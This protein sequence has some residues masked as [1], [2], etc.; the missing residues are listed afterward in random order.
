MRILGAVLSVSLLSGVALAQ[1]RP[2]FSG[3]R[4]G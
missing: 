1:E 2:D 4:R 3:H